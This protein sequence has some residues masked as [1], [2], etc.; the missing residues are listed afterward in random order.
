M[1]CVIPGPIRFCSQEQGT[2]VSAWVIDR[3]VQ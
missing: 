3:C 2:G 1:A